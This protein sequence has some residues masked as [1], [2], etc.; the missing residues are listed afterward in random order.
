MKNLFF[1][2]VTEI[3]CRCFHTFLCFRLKAIGFYR[4]ISLSIKLAAK[5]IMNYLF[6]KIPA[7]VSYFDVKLF[8][9]NRLDESVFVFFILR[10]PP[11]KTKNFNTIFISIIKDLSHILTFLICDKQQKLGFITRTV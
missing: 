3:S 1:S 8:F 5:L 7:Y 9:S 11:K 10:F 6:E 2:S 4:N